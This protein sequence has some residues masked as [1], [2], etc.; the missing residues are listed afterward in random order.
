VHPRRVDPIRQLTPVAGRKRR[1]LQDS[2][3]DVGRRIDAVDRELRRLAEQRR[4]L[5]AQRRALHRRLW[6]NLA[7]RG[8]RAMP[9]G[10]RALPPLPPDATMLWGRRLRA[11]CRSLMA[12]GGA[13]PLGELHA[14]LHRRGYGVDHPYPV[15]AL[16]DALGY[17]TM[18]GRTRRVARG[19]YE[20]IPLIPQR[21]RGSTWLS[22]A[23]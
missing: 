4:A 2:Y 6:I 11:V 20:L 10:G 14:E 5:V 21:P 16:A 17:E 7:K 19:V 18:L 15:K 22:A 13:V 8:R 23:G 1:E 9:D 3:S 12:G